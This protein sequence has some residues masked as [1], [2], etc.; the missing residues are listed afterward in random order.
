[1]RKEY[2]K[3]V[4][5]RIPEIIRQDGRQCGVEVMPE[6]EYVQALKDKLIEEAQEAATAGSDDLVKELADLYEVVDALMAAC[7]IDR[8]V[9]LAKQEER[10]QSRGGFDQRL[11][12]LWTD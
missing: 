10:R 8:Q 12:L 3:L 6:G 5:D 1:M 7:G 11:R 4:R 9:V 2:D